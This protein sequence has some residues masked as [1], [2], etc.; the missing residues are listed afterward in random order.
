M[1]WRGFHMGISPDVV[2]LSIRSARGKIGYDDRYFMKREL[3]HVASQKNIR[4]DQSEL[5]F[6]VFDHIADEFSELFQ[7]ERIDGLI[8]KMGRALIRAGDINGVGTYILIWSPAH[9]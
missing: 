7:I 4:V 3:D 8:A 2:F 5:D 9:V 6:V 1:L